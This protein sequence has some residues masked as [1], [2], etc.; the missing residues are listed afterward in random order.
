MVSELCTIRKINKDIFA[1]GLLSIITT[2]IRSVKFQP[3]VICSGNAFGSFSLA[4]SGYKATEYAKGS[5]FQTPQ[6][7]PTL[8]TFCICLI[9]ID[10][11][12]H[13]V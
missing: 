1:S 7:L 8:H 13:M 5:P 10:K 9:L 2:T 11:E 4:C 6:I 12:L 3:Y